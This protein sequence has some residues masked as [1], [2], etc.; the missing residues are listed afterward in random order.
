MLQNKKSRPSS[1]II[2]NFHAKNLLA[3]LAFLALASFIYSAA[4]SD[5]RY[6]VSTLNSNIQS[7]IR[8]NLDIIQNDLYVRA[9]KIDIGLLS[10][11]AA[12]S[13]D[14]LSELY[15]AVYIVD[16]NSTLRYS[17]EFAGT[18]ELK[19]FDLPWLDALAK[20]PFVVSS[21]AYR[22][23]RAEAV[24][25]AFRLSH[26]KRLIVELNLKL[27]SV[28]ISNAISQSSDIAFLCDK[29]G[30]LLSDEFSRFF[31][32]S[33]YIKYLS[34]GDEFGESKTIF[35]PT[36]MSLEVIDYM[37][38]YEIFVITGS[39]KNNE[40]LAQCLFLAVS[41]FCFAA[42]VLLWIKDTAFTKKNISAPLQDIL[43]F[44]RNRSKKADAKFAVS[45]LEEINE[46]VEA[47]Y[48]KIDEANLALESYK[49]RFGYVFEQGSLNILVYDAY[50]GDIVDVSSNLLKATG[51][52][53]EQILNLNIKDLVYSSFSDMVY[54]RREAIEKGKPFKLKAVFKNGQIRDISV[55]DSPIEL[56]GQRLNFVVA[57]DI[58]DEQ[59]AS[60]NDEII[61]NYM[62]V[63]P[64][65]IMIAQ[66]DEP[67][68]ITQ[69]TNNANLVFG[70]KDDAPIDLRAL[71]CGE[72]LNEFINAIEVAKKLFV[73]GD[74]SKETLDFIVKMT[75]RGGQKTPFKVYVKF[76]LNEENEFDKIVYS[77]S[78]LSDLAK[79]QERYDADQKSFKNILW[80]SEAVV[81]SWSKTSGVMQVDDGFAKMLG[82]NDANE[83]GVLDFKRFK[84]LL[85]GSYASFEK[86]FESM[87]FD[88]SVYFGELKFH[89]KDKSAVYIGVRAR[90]LEFDE[91]GEA[92]LIKGAFKN[93]TQQNQALIYQ[94]LLCKLFSYAKEGVAT[95][96]TDLKIIDAN[97]AFCQ[98]CGYERDEI[99]AKDVAFIKPG[100]RGLTQDMT[101][102]AKGGFWQSKILNKNKN[103]ENRFELVRLAPLNDVQG[104]LFCYVLLVSNINDIESNQDYLE[105][106]AY[107]DPLTR[108]PN[109]ILFTRKLEDMLAKNDK[110]IA[111][112]YLDMDGFK[113]INDT[114]GHQAGDKFLTE[115]SSGIDRL[116]DERDMFARIGGDEFVAIIVYK[117]AGEVYEIVQNMLRIASSEVWYENVKLQISASIGVSMASLAQ[118][119]AENLL[120]QADWAMYQAKLGGKNRY[121]VFDASKDRNFKNQYEEASKILKALRDD[122]IFLEYQ[123]EIDIKTSKILSYEALIRWQNEGRVIYPD[124]FLPLIKKQYIIDDIAL[125]SIKKALEAQILWSKNGK[126]AKAC[127]NLNIEQLCSDEFFAKFKE[128][129]NADKRLNFSELV[130]DI[131]DANAVKDLQPAQKALQRYKRF[132][133]RFVLDDFASHSSSFEAL[134][135]LKVERFKV[136]KQ[137]SRQAFDSKASIMTL[138]MI[139]QISDVFGLKA[140]IKNIEDKMTLEILCG[141][142]FECF[143]G[144]FFT[145]PLR[146]DEALR[147]EF[148][149]I[150]GLDIKR[151]IDDAQFERLK[152]CVE[153]KECALE[154]V[155]WLQ[156]EENLNE[157][158]KDEIAKKIRS[159]N[160]YERICAL[161]KRALSAQNKDEALRLANEANAMCDEILKDMNE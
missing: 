81:F 47:L 41:I 69:S 17:R 124:D 22:G 144:N 7:S 65:V 149:G 100:L 123:P 31:K 99:L 152:E 143:Q 75:G 111:I 102:A 33:K 11:E 70:I 125:F 119:S 48:E 136:D 24:Y 88:E 161:L 103:G 108:L 53:R 96:S 35:S 104:G 21:R 29:N 62:F 25:A 135:L 74:G 134:G 154:I 126:D 56:K 61:K 52:T 57:K 78:D 72:N 36:D 105:Y 79:L 158:I 76:I 66:K 148:K 127:V 49:S 139:K 2:K 118:I 73:M 151:H 131:V 67:F 30:N 110:H 116:F 87:R 159:Q 12:M 63:S 91:N 89:A 93:L 40:I 39:T 27:L 45:E 71:V 44:L 58:T 9:Q 1:W 13:D 18:H 137:L 42:F 46:S 38:D 50:T 160:P 84:A 107:H 54:Y 112:A 156:N 37:K 5:V 133:V 153:L 92:C 80:A 101:K 109:R 117:N 115:I 8:R 95:L 132:G 142:G 4:K 128:L 28:S 59:N 60:R 138:R 150:S 147:Y 94:D 83:L 114:Y 129:A 120:E 20:R 19:N 43:E 64:S 122:E 32:R 146:L 51:Y 113:G 155:S 26:G 15:N 121:Y 3:L 10:E 68:I 82:F 85:A 97:D 16:A 106:I 14:S 130:I 23:G 55:M 141:F 6:E 90:A 140:T 77:F 157:D 98:M 145:K 86:L 34:L